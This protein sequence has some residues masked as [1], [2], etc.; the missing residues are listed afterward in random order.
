MQY[1]NLISVLDKELYPLL[2]KNSNTVRYLI[3]FLNAYFWFHGKNRITS[4]SILSAKEFTKNSDVKKRIHVHFK[5]EKKEYFYE[6]KFSN[7]IRDEKQFDPS[8]FDFANYYWYQKEE[9]NNY[10]IGQI[11]LNFKEGLRK[12]PIVHY[13]LKNEQLEPMKDTFDIHILYVSSLKRILKTKSYD[14]L[15]LFERWILLLQCKTVEEAKQLC[16]GEKYMLEFLSIWNYHSRRIQYKRLSNSPNDTLHYL[17]EKN[18]LAIKRK[19][20]RNLLLAG[21]SVSFVEKVIELKLTE[22]EKIKRVIDRK[23]G[24]ND[25]T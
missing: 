19:I 7:D 11:I 18:S 1:H 20:A 22:I 4:L 24:I 3:D 13:Y 17:L 2:W 9:E 5:Q 16:I 15:N 25:A 23:E 8:F 6:I 14:E 10:K 21:C 12:N